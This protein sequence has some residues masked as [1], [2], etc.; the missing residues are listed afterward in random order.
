ME[1]VDNMEKK[2]YFANICIDKNLTN[3]FEKKCGE[4]DV[5]IVSKETVNSKVDKPYVHYIVEA[6]DGKIDPKW[7]L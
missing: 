6:E 2:L 4:K 5:K 3:Y 7:K 1:G